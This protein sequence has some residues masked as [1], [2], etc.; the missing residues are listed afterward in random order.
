[1][2]FGVTIDGFNRKSLQEIRSEIEDDFRS[3]FGPSI[4]LRDD[5]LLG[6]KIGIFSE[7]LAL[8]WER[9]EE[10]FNSQYPDTANGLPLD[11]VLSY[12]GLQRLPA[13]KSTVIVTASGTPGTIIPLGSVVS[14]LGTGAKFESTAA[15]TIGGGGTVDILFE[16]QSTGLIQALAGTLTVIETPITGWTGATNALDAILG[17]NIETDTQART[18]RLTALQPARAA[19]PDAVRARLLNVAGVLDATIIENVLDIPDIDGR[20]GHSYE[21]V[22]AG[23]D[24]QDLFDTIWLTKPAGIETVGSEVGTTLDSQGGTQEV[25]FS[26]PVTVDIFMEVDLTLNPEEIFPV[27]GTDQ[28]EQAIVDF[29]TAEQRLGEDV[30]LSKFFGPIHTIPGIATIVIRADTSPSPVSTSN[31]I[32]DKNELAVFLLANTTVTVV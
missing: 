5:S 11:N 1:M 10:V 32:I 3:V 16:S 20:P 31:V 27:D 6:I 23:G 7:Q 12:T 30:I 29:G 28:V 9:L 15:D 13:T 17:R 25:K 8:L 26:R 4:N 18:R 19:T 21:P 24:D 2:A 22:I 14:V